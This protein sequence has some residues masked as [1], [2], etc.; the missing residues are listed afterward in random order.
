MAATSLLLGNLSL[1]EISSFEAIASKFT[2]QMRFSG[3]AC[4]R[5]KPNASVWLGISPSADGANGALPP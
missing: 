3:S 2:F 4:G 1:S 5:K